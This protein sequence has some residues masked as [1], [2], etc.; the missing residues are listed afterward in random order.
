MTEKFHYTVG[1]KKITLPRFGN[2]PFGVIRKIRKLD[3]VEQLFTLFELVL[4][5]DPD[6]LAIIDTMEQEAVQELIVAWQKDS[7]VTV[8]ESEESADS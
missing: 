2:L 3:E 1:K 4:D 8:G 5:K 7:G 6:T